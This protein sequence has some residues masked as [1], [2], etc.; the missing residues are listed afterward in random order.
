M[1]KNI[2]ARTKAAESAC[3]TQV[4]SRSFKK[5]MLVENLSKHVLAT[6]YAVR[7]KIPMLGEHINNQIKQGVKYPFEDTISLNIGNPQALGQP[8]ITFNREVLA[9]LLL[10]GFSSHSI[11][12]SS[13]RR[14]EKYKTLL[15]TPVGKLLAVLIMFRC[16]Y[17]KFKGIPSCKGEDI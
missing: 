12:Q 8:S 7:G 10:P 1:L 5:Q 13:K 14:A 4:S 16:I 9:Q 11:S 6:D 15:S 17:R 3:L 2:L